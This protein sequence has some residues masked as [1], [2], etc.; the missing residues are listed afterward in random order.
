MG[1]LMFQVSL[2][3]VSG[4]TLRKLGRAKQ[5]RPAKGVGGGGGGKREKGVLG[6][7]KNHFT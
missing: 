2:I 3:E 7:E 6:P 4:A 5:K 1:K